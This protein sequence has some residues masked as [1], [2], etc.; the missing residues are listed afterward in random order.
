MGRVDRGEAP[1]RGRCVVLS[2]SAGPEAIW[3]DIVE[4][5]DGLEM[6]TISPRS[7]ERAGGWA[8]SFSQA[9][10]AFR[11]R[12][13]IVVALGERLAVCAS[14]LRLVHGLAFFGKPPLVV[15]YDYGANADR[16]GFAKRWRRLATAGVYL[17]V[18]RD[19]DERLR[20]AA[21]L[22]RNKERF[23]VHSLSPAA[24][25]GAPVARGDLP[26]AARYEFRYLLINL[27]DQKRSGTLL[28]S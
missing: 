1:W 14:L 5:G 11:A 3:N 6:L 9:R 26:E 28:F 20:Q 7:P 18:V 22:L 13:D 27:A 12:P 8:E 25:R 4:A 15:A 23:L 16:S 21:E 24:P 19:Q 17:Y 10:R 2:P